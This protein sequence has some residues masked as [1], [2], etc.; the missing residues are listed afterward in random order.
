M[1]ILK[2][3]KKQDSS[4]TSLHWDRMLADGRGKSDL[5]WRFMLNQIHLD[6]RSCYRKGIPHMWW[7]MGYEDIHRPLEK[8]TLKTPFQD[9]ALSCHWSLT[10]SKYDT[11]KASGVPLKYHLFKFVKEITTLKV[12]SQHLISYDVWLSH[13]LSNEKG[14][15]ES[16]IF[17]S[18]V[19]TLI[20]GF[21]VFLSNFSR[22]NIKNSQHS[23][24]DH[25]NL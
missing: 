22:K 13:Y 7:W 21:A 9:S 10:L 20:P 3:E 14:W 5:C 1:G 6:S 19:D 15:N 24:M 23:L 12:L 4:D 11:H 8:T 25:F 2:I 17:S 18:L 16:H